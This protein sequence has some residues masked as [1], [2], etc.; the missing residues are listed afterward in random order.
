MPT[1]LLTCPKCGSSF[2][3][4]ATTNTRCRSCR[5]VVNVPRGNPSAPRHAASKAS[6][7][8]LGLV[9]E[10]GHPQIAW[11]VGEDEKGALGTYEWHCAECDDFKDVD[12]VAGAMTS[13]EEDDLV[14]EELVANLFGQDPCYDAAWD[15][16]VG[17]SLNDQ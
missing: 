16:L 4:N 1:T 12:R 3:T 8:C 15:L 5:H 17:F 14:I 10:C 6:T 13:V 7:Y 2:E 11:D 9:L